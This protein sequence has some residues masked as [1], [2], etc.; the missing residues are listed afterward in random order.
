MFVEWSLSYQPRLTN[1][2]IR[3]LPNA[4]GLFARSTNTRVDYN[5]YR[6]FIDSCINVITAELPSPA[7]IDATCSSFL[8]A[9][10]FVLF[11]IWRCTASFGEADF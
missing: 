8:A 5:P 2:D 6:W 3:G 9:T 10:L 4:D 11:F 7:T 1:S